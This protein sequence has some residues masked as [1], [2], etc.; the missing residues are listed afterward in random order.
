MLVNNFENLLLKREDFVSRLMMF[1]LP[2]CH[3]R[4]E[5]LEKDAQAECFYLTGWLL[6]RIVVCVL[7]H[8]LSGLIDGVKLEVC[9]IYER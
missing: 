3:C 7:F 2:L 1:E 4:P 5:I 8:W 9:P 6:R